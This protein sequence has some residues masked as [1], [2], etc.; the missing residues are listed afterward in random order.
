MGVLVKGVGISRVLVHECQGV[1]LCY[2]GGE[3]GKDARDSGDEGESEAELIE[4]VG[5]SA[6]DVAWEY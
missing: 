4:D 1:G 3:I 2:D 5:G 6:K